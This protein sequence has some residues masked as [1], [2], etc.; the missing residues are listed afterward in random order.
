MQGGRGEV[1]GEVGCPP[2][3]DPVIDD[4]VILWFSASVR[5]R[6]ERTGH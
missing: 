2:I 6:G 5:S 1:P 3:G 4:P